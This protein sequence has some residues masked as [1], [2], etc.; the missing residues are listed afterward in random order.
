MVG[1]AGH[2]VICKIG[3]GA[4]PEVFTTIPGVIEHTLM[5]RARQE[6]NYTT[7]DSD[8]IHKIQSFKDNG[9]HVL[10][11]AYDS[12]N[13]VHQTLRDM[14]D[15]GELSNFETTLPDAGAEVIEYAASVNNWQPMASS[16][17]VLKVQVTLSVTAGLTYS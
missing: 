6:I 17:D 4:S 14:Y 7:H 13:T 9:Q 1:K 15:S 11:L 5:N 3:N 10:V 12:S 2:G 16:T 8:G